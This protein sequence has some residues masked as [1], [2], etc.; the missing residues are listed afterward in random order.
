MSAAS[1]RIVAKWAQANKHL[2]GKIGKNIFFVWRTNQWP[3]VRETLFSYIPP[4]NSLISFWDSWMAF[5][6]DTTPL[7]RSSFWLVRC[8]LQRN[9]DTVRCAMWDWVVAQDTA[10]DNYR[11][12]W[13]RVGR[14]R[15]CFHW[16]KNWKGPGPPIS[17]SELDL[18]AS[19]TTP[20]SSWTGWRFCLTTAP[21]QSGPN[22]LPGWSATWTKRWTL[23]RS[24]THTPADPGRSTIP[25]QGVATNQH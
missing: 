5:G 18:T 2:W 9:K 23:A 17:D 10:K 12:P 16:S 25:Y 21:R 15:T 20:A 7:D 6:A 22:R 14:K 8:E 13:L 1:P 4:R 3:L 24:S 11:K 19:L